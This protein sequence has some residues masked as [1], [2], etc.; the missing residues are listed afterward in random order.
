MPQARKVYEVQS[1]DGRTFEVEGDRPPTQAELQSI[2]SS[3]GAAKQP[4][5]NDEAMAS[6]REMA[7]M[8]EPL[9]DAELDVPVLQRST[10]PAMV[11]AMAVPAMAANPLMRAAG[12]PV[13]MASIKASLAA[14]RGANLGDIAQEG[15]EGYVTGAGL[16]ALGGKVPGVPARILDWIR[17]GK[18]VAPVAAEAKVAAEAVPAV[19]VK[20]FPANP[21]E[22]A[23]AM[24][25]PKV[26]RAA[27]AP[28]VAPESSTLEEQLRETVKLSKGAR[29]QLSA[30]QN[31]E[32]RIV[33]WKTRQGQSESQIVDSLKDIF[34]IREP[35]AAKEMVDLVLR[36]HG[37]KR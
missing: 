25:A 28:K 29:K 21:T 18:T 1:P 7:K 20:A 15:V 26:V 34:G 33:E 27:P 16:G 4:S 8:H 9:S 22:A 5:R 36:T 32:A 17:R 23:A 19:A 13:G 30:A 6:L 37:L 31:L 24:S 10:A 35:G 12:S 14:A 2:F 11:G 3:L